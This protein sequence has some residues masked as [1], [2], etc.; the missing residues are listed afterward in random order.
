MKFVETTYN[1]TE[2][3]FKY[4]NAPYV[5]VSVMVSDAGITANADGK[6]IVP[7]G[8]IVGGD[9]KSVL[10]NPGEPVVKKNTQGL[11]TGAAGAAVDAEGVLAN[12][13]DVTHGTAPGTMLIH[14]F[15]DKSK[16]PEVPAAEAVAAL[17]MIK[18][19]V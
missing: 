12:A 13:V 16:L 14:A 9:T 5:G 2:T 17:N 4:A 10:D 3:I 8:T 11:A 7:A 6:K 18:F 15:I 19:I 1:N